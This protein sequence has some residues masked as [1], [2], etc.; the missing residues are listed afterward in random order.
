MGKRK[1]RNQQQILPSGNLHSRRGTRLGHKCLLKHEAERV[2]CHRDIDIILCV[3]RA[4]SECFQLRETRED[5]TN[6]VLLELRSLRMGGRALVML[7][8]RE[9]NIKNDMYLH[10]AIRQ[11]R[12]EFLLEIFESLKQQQKRCEFQLQFHLY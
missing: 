5:V 6:N 4:G 2:D 11:R 8:M 7:V 9:K 12:K 3:C 1:Q 10:I